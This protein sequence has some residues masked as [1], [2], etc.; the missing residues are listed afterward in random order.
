MNI[1][2]YILPF[3]FFSCNTS[4]QDNNMEK[5]VELEEMN[6]CI[7]FLISSPSK[8]CLYSVLIKENGCSEMIFTDLRTIGGIKT[9]KREVFIV[10][11]V[12]DIGCL[13]GLF[14]ELRKEGLC[15]GDLWKGGWHYKVLIGK[16]EKIEV[17][18]QDD[19]KIVMLLYD[20]IQKYS[21]IKINYNCF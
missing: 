12:E 20:L 6:E 15:K 3:V 2:Y 21:S 11:S 14:T 5:K 13:K 8:R 16:K 7:E 9:R 10:S 18:K 1:F 4:L 17:Y 19:S